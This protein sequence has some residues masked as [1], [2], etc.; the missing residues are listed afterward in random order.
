M[1]GSGDRLA[2]LTIEDDI[3]YVRDGFHEELEE[4]TGKL[5]SFVYDIPYFGA[6]GV[7]PP[8]HIVNFFFASGTCGGGM[9]PGT[10][11][12]PFVIDETTYA[13]LVDQVLKTNPAQLEGKAR[14]IEVQFIEDNSLDDIQDW[15]TWS[16]AACEKHRDWYHG[17]IKQCSSE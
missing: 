12:S 16:Q 9:G 2:F 4:I 13:A 7:F 6:C 15:F 1:N 11:W 10:S 3:S 14:F 8:L 5:L 17:K